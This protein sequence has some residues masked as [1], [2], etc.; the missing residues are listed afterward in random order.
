V[1][2]FS[3]DWMIH[4]DMLKF[5]CGHCLQWNFKVNLRDLPLLERVGIGNG[6]PWAG[7]PTENH[8][9]SLLGPLTRSHSPVPVSQPSIAL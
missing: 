8:P 5:L 9:N 6:A 3:A 7:L 2:E 1:V 4:L